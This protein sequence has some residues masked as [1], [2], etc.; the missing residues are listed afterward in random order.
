MKKLICVLLLV[1]ICFSFVAC[2][3]AEP[4]TVI[5]YIEVPVEVEKIVE[6]P[7]EIIIEKE[8]AVPAC[9]QCVCFEPNYT[10]TDAE[11]G[12]VY[13]QTEC[14]TCGA[15]F[16]R[17]KVPYYEKINTVFVDRE[18]VIEKEVPI[19]VVIEKEIIVEKEVIVERNCPELR[20]LRHSDFWNLE[21]GD[22]LE[23]VVFGRVTNSWIQ[24]IY[25]DH[26][27]LMD[28]KSYGKANVPNSDYGSN[29]W[30]GTITVVKGQ[31]VDDPPLILRFSNCI[32]LED[33]I[34][35]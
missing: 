23:N 9:E 27:E 33:Y 20:F 32:E 12:Y 28:I 16:D 22:V 8:I 21:E 34:T 30:I 35:N 2:V 26:A 19:E 25:A 6:V 7:V 17:V 31:Y 11:N 10:L 5:E 14:W 18:V 13:I 29:V 1:C 15:I 24:L 4:E 3:N